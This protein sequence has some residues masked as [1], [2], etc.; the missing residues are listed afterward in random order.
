MIDGVKRFARLALVP[1]SFMALAFFSCDSAI[2]YLYWAIFVSEI[3]SRK[4]V[5]SKVIFVA[6]LLF[7]VYTSQFIMISFVPSITL[8]VL[9]KKLRHRLRNIG[10]VAVIYCFFVFLC[11]GELLQ[12]FL[13]FL[14]G[15]H[16]DPLAHLL[17]V[18]MA[19]GIFSIYRAAENLV[20]RM[21][22][23]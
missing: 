4:Y 5:N 22:R 9:T 19:T 10:S 17:R 8:Y 14:M 3:G 7:D 13:T 21:I 15:A 12:S 6:S 20:P 2:C 23:N 16:A 18:L 1:T 11:T